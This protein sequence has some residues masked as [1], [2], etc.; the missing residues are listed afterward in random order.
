MIEQGESDKK[1]LSEQSQHSLQV[2]NKKLEVK[3]RDLEHAKSDNNEL[4]RQRDKQQQEFKAVYNEKQELYEKI[5]ELKDQI[6]SERCETKDKIM[7]L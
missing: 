1:A 6:S 3:L 4:K 5:I 7:S 2:Q